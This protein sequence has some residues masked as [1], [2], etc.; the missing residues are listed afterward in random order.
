MLVA[1]AAQQTNCAI[2]RETLPSKQPQSL[3]QLQA[4]RVNALTG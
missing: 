3:W 4:A 2:L 1:A